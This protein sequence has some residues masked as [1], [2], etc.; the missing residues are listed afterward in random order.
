[1]LTTIALVLILLYMLELRRQVHEM[2]EALTKLH[3]DFLIEAEHKYG[4]ILNGKK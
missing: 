1:M 2:S 4:E 3:Q